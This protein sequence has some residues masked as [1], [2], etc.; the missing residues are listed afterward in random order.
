MAKIVTSPVTTSKTVSTPA[1]TSSPAATK[2][3]KAQAV[4]VDSRK[5]GS[6]EE[7]FLEVEERVCVHPLLWIRGDGG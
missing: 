3:G 2:A 6:S 7:V 5:C 1:T 4:V